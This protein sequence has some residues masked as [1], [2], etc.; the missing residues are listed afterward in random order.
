MSK[1]HP[2]DFTNDAQIPCNITGA[3]ACFVQARLHA[4]LKTD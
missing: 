2:R 3:S 1:R 4:H